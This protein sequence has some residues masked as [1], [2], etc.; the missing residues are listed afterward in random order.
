M[1]SV[2]FS[3]A[4]LARFLYTFNVFR[5]GDGTGYDVST[6]GPPAK[7][8]QTAAVTA[9]RETGVVAQN[10][11]PAC[12]TAQAGGTLFRHTVIVLDD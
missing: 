4:F 11:A 6:A 3:M 7:I 10:N 5:I 1:L 8:N 12:G 2:V 9:K